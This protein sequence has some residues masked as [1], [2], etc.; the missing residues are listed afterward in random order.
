ML[1]YLFTTLLVLVGLA[2]IWFAW[3][4]VYKLFQGQR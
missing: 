3:L 1:E 4:T 2:T